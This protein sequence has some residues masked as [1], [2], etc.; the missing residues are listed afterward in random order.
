MLLLETVL[1]PSLLTDIERAKPKRGFSVLLED[2]KSKEDCPRKPPE[3]KDLLPMPFPVADSDCWR[4][5]MAS[6]WSREFM[7]VCFGFARRRKRL[8]V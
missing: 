2:P 1:A 6:D 7:V 8:S 4:I 5:Q 3:L